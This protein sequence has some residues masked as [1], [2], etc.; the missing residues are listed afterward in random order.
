MDIDDDILIQKYET[1]LYNRESIYFDSEEFCTII[2]HYISKTRYADAL[3]A[4]IHAE[5]CHPE[6]MELELYK[7]KIMMYLDNFDRAFD[8]L[9]DM[10]NRAYD[11]FEINLYK[12]HIYAMNDEIENAIREFNLV[13]EKNPDFD[14]D[15]LLYIPNVLVEQ[16]YFD[17]ALVFLHR[18]VDSG[19]VSAKI[20][21][22]IGHC[23]EQLSNME[24]AEEYY[25]KSLDEDS[26]N[27]KT[28]ITLGILHLGTGNA[29]KA[30]D[31][32]EFASSINSE[33]HI[34]NLCKSAAL[35]EAGEYD[36]AIECILEVMSKNPDYPDMSDF[37]MS[38]MKMLSS[39]EDDTENAGEDGDFEMPYWNLA[40]ILFVQGSFEEAIM[41]LD[42][43]LEIEPD[44]EDYLYFRG[45][46]FISLTPNRKKLKTALRKLHITKKP[47]PEEDRDSE[48]LDRHKKAVFSYNVR[49][50]DECCRYLA[51]SL[52]INSKGL[53]QFF[54]L[55][56]NAKDK[57]A[58]IIG[59]GRY[60][61]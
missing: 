3:E 1:L 60:I 51:E 50:Y 44:N 7:A 52:A 58:I 59:L 55:C 18:F 19:I 36:K 15:E 2:S 23:Y 17:E 9:L 53:E 48:F 24:K 29:K 46:C 26:F 25:E 49:N 13:L 5:L 31:A 61:K 47:E 4:Q 35:I 14:E 27:E 11:S 41:I 16:K 37:E 6:D 21:F 34:V 12:G 8:L 43:A 33:S 28:W 57:A 20:F 39:G 54:N 10:E 40:K 22:N 30:L 56:P 38:S 45:Q 32:F 42:K